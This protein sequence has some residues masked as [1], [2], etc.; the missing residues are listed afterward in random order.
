MLFAV[1]FVAY[2]TVQHA[3]RR[4]W[5]TARGKDLLDAQRSERPGLRN[6]PAGPELP[7]AVALFGTGVL[8][9]AAPEIATAYMTP[10]D[11]A[12]AR[13]AAPA[14]GAA[15]ELRARP[16]ASA[17]ASASGRSSKA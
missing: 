4:R 1:G 5:A 13:P 15:D 2:W 10:R 11:G 12:R 8:W 16:R 14:A 6:R 17:S 7:L 3:R 9:V